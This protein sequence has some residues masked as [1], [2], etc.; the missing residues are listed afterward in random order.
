MMKENDYLCPSG[1]LTPESFLLGV[2][3][4]NGEAHFI[5]GPLPLS[6]DLQR[7]LG[8]ISNPEKH[9]RFTMRC[10]HNGCGQWADG[11]CSVAAALMRADPEAGSLPSGECGI[12]S[13]C[14]WLA[15]EGEAAC[16]ICKYIVTDVSL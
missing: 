9:F 6:G 8:D 15:Q 3:N 16:T 10:H 11:K 2:L 1:A 4:K 7:M 5:G 13:A 14:R 12:K